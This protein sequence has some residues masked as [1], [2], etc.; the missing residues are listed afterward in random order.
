MKYARAA[1]ALHAHCKPGPNGCVTGYCRGLYAT[2][3]NAAT[4]GVYAAARAAAA[5]AR[6]ACMSDA[7]SLSM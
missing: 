7:E 6:D 3:R 5:A 2:M 1:Y 4:G